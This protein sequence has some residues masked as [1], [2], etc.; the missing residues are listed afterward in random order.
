MRRAIAASACAG[1]PLRTTS[2]PPRALKSA[3]SASTPSTSMSP[4]SSTTNTLTNAQTRGRPRSLPR[5]AYRALSSHEPSGLRCHASTAL[6]GSGDCRSA[7]VASDSCVAAAAS[8]PSLASERKTRDARGAVV[9][10]ASAANTAC[11]HTS[12][13]VPSTTSA[14]LGSNT[15]SLYAPPSDSS[16]TPPWPSATSASPKATRAA[17]GPRLT[18]ANG[19]AKARESMCGGSQLLPSYMLT[20]HA[21]GREGRRPLACS[22]SAMSAIAGGKE[23]M[24]RASTRLACTRAP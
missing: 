20:E 22:A 7:I 2:P 8:A 23:G 19:L 3:R 9:R 21:V 16:L 10:G 24:P 1:S 14:D 4:P 11:L 12:A 13:A 15:S 17:A 6:D 5:S 18:T